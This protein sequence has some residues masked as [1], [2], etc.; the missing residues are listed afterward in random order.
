MNKDP[1]LVVDPFCVWCRQSCPCMLSIAWSMIRE[2]EFQFS[3][4][5]ACSVGCMITY[6][7][8]SLPWDVRPNVLAI[9]RLHV[10]KTLGILMSARVA[11]ATGPYDPSRTTL[12]AWRRSWGWEPIPRCIETPVVPV[13]LKLED[14]PPKVQKPDLFCMRKPRQV[15]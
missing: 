12:V 13:S 5:A 1:G 15:Y 9:N 2:D 11:E 14:P 10:K 3:G 4:R 8:Q 6:L 7:K